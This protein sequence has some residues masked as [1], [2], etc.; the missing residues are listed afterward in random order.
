[1]WAGWILTALE[2]EAGYFLVISIWQEHW[3]LG[4]YNVP[5]PQNCQLKARSP[6]TSVL[7]TVLNS[8]V[9]SSASPTSLQWLLV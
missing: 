5:K 7:P 2:I 3:P 1:M 9:W 8:S 6:W 4:G